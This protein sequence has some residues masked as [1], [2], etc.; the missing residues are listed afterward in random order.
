MKGEWIREPTA[1]TVVV[2]VHGIM[3]SG[4][5]CWQ[6]ENGA[7]WPELLR[8][9]PDFASVGIYIFTYQTNFFSRNYSLSRVVDDLKESLGLDDVLQRQQKIIFVC[10]SMGGIVARKYIVER[11]VD[12]LEC[13]ASLGVFLVASPSLGSEY[14]E[15]LKP[16]AK[17]LGHSQADAIRFADDNQWLNSLDKEFKNL[18]GRDRTGNHQLSIEGKEL[19]ENMFLELRKFPVLLKWVWKFTTWRWTQLVPPLSSERYFPEPKMISGSDH[20]SIA[21]PENKNAEQ[22]RLLCKFIKDKF[23]RSPENKDSNPVAT[24][25]GTVADGAAAP[26]TPTGSAS[27][28]VPRAV[29]TGF[30]PIDQRALELA[31]LDQLKEEEE[32]NQERQEKL[33]TPL[34]GK[35]QQRRLE[36]R[37]A[38]ER[39]SAREGQLLPPK[40]V[41]N[42]VEEILEMRQA[43]LLGE[44]GSGKT[45]TICLLT[46][47]LLEAAEDSDK[48]IPLFIRLGRWTDEQQPLT[49][50]IASQ[51][52]EL[53]SHLHALLK[54]KRAALLLDGLNELPVGHR[55]NKYQQ[56]Q[57][58]IQQNKDLLALV[59]CRELD[60][61]GQIDLKF[62]RINIL[63]LDPIRIREFVCRDLGDESGERM[64]WTLAGQKMQNTY[65]EFMQEFS[66]KLSEPEQVFWL[67]SQLPTGVFWGWRGW[68][69]REQSNDNSSW[70]NWLKLRETP[71]S[72]MLMA[73]NPYLLSMLNAEF[74]DAGKLP[75]NRGD[76]FRAFVERLLK[77]EREILKGESEQDNLQQEQELLIP[78]LARLAF[79]MQ[80]RRSEDNDD[81][82][83]TAL[84]RATAQTIL[85]ARQLTMAGSASLLN[86]G[87]QVR[88]SHQLLQEYFAA[89]FMDIELHAGRL[90]ASKLWTRDQWWERSNWEEAAVLLAGLYTDDCTP[91]VNWL[92]DANPEVA[93]QCIKRSGAEIEPA[94]LDQLRK[95][96]TPRL[97]D[98]KNEPNPLARAAVGRALGLIGDTRRGVN[99]KPNADGV[100][101]PDI[102]WVEIPGGEFQYGST[103]QSSPKPEKITLPTFEI[104]RYPITYAQ[105][106]TFLNDPEG[107]ADP[108][109]FEGLAADDDGRQMSEQAFKYYDFPYTNH[110]R[111]TVNWYQAMAFCRWLSW[112]L[113]GGYD[114]KKI[115]EWKVRLP[116]EF[117]WEKAAR[118]TDGRLYPYKGEYDPAKGNTAKTGIGQTSAVGIFPNGASPYG[119]MEMSGN[120]WEWCLSNYENST[121]KAREENLRTDKSRVLR[122]GSWYNLLDFARA[123]YRNDLHPSNR[124]FS[125]GFRVVV[126]PLLL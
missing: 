68:S 61:D 114:L 93:A 90:D 89:K 126:V 60:Y 71:S 103:E 116:T 69:S 123:V 44:P 48:P 12:L 34:K 7:Y 82:A 62:D 86:L 32:L 104:S 64:F 22:H 35:A 37:A 76:L 67:D 13:Q 45:T 43:A 111:E 38:Y 4:E 115:D 30:A 74:A 73:R 122:G 95:Q 36:A 107:F 55:K 23:L 26:E 118:G 42:A 11:V 63:P 40:I 85:T 59:S 75:D 8:D 77:R 108:R 58:F 102:E 98:L 28:T 5:A 119:V 81:G 14:A 50:F 121:F 94:T 53:G 17:Y 125:F 84:P 106:Q 88:F 1:G 105:F 83:T 112:R 33:Y 25:P 21:K 54:A 99:V 97:T 31:Y 57:T 92:S 24:A 66:A 70:E 113:G 87:E 52:G 47:K 124:D 79:E 49:E 3:S 41:P 100:L 9:E 20:S 101:L 96:W 72:L 19:T 110:P 27:G 29:A 117:E 51:M 2:F 56:V 109:W 10:H 78:D 18:V 15:W 80:T 39:V 91:I 65:Q 46:V 16:V 120:V 6:H